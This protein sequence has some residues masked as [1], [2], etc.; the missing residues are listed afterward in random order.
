MVSPLVH[1]GFLSTSG[2]R[3]RRL[4]RDQVGLL[5]GENSEQSGLQLVLGIYALPRR[6]AMPQNGA[7]LWIVW[8]TKHLATSDGAIRFC[9][10]PE[11]A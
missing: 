4:G 9:E 5:A 8:I 10:I 7:A 11:V 3:P 2:S 6:I 1:R